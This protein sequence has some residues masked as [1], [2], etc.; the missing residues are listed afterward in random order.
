M[1]QMV[2]IH[3]TSLNLGFRFKRVV[4]METEMEKEEEEQPRSN[5]LELRESLRGYEAQLEEAKLLLNT[6]P[7]NQEYVQ[8]EKALREVVEMTQD[9]LKDAEQAE[10][11]EEEEEE[12]RGHASVDDA[13][14]AVH[15]STSTAADMPIPLPF[16]G[17]GSYWQPGEVCEAKYSGDG[18]WYK[19]KI[20]HVR[21]T[22]G[23]VAAGGVADGGA[24][25]AGAGLRARGR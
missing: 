19:A 15:P 25:R 4:V 8:L 7:E 2:A 3:L 18:R 13:A 20:V 17:R 1:T 5:V 10:E 14:T 12:T 21:T 16:A 6:E 23:G 24:E 9:I 22:G 11:E